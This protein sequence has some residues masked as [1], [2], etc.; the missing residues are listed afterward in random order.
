MMSLP[1][2]GKSSA[3][4]QSFC[5]AD[6]LQKSIGCVGIQGDAILKVLREEL[7]GE[8][9]IEEQSLIT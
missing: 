4:V 6:Q 3:N 5:V 8:P 1:C 9:C 2:C 7:K